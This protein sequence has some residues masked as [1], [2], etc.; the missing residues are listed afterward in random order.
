MRM[1]P[2]PM[3]PPSEP[4]ALQV[5]GVSKHFGSTQALRRVDLLVERASVHALLG[6]NGS[7]K[8]T[9]IKVLAGFHQADQG[10]ISV[11][12]QAIQAHH[13]PRQ[14][15]AAGLR[16]VHQDLGLVPTLSVAENLAL[17][18][19]FLTR[20][21]GTIGWRRQYEHAV[22]ELA[23][24]DIQLDPRRT[25]ATLGPVEQTMVA[26]TRSLLGIEHDRS[27][28]FLD[29]PT[30]RLPRSEVDRLL[31]IVNTLRTRGVAVVYVTHRLDEVFASADTV[32]ILRDGS[33]VFTSSVHGTDESTVSDIIIGRGGS[34]D[35]GPAPAS[36]FSPLRIAAGA[37]AMVGA[38]TTLPG[39][40]DA[41]SVLELR[42]I[43]GR[44]VQGVSLRLAPGEIVAV[45][46]LVGSGRSELGRLIYGIQPLTGGEVW[47]AGR[48]V[49]R[50][51]PRRAKE[52]GLGYSPQERSQA[53]VSG[54][55]VGENLAIT[56]YSGLQ[57]LLGV[58]RRRLRRMAQTVVSNLAIRPPDPDSVVDT[59]SG[60]NQQKVALGKWIRQPLRLLILD[61]PLQGID[62][63][64]KEDIMRAIQARTVRDGL[65]V[66]WLESD[67]QEV[68]KYAT[69]TFVMRDGRI[70]TELTGEV[71]QARLLKAVYDKESIPEATSVPS[72]RPE[73]A[74]L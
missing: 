40:P 13:N 25:L 2:E 1:I 51:T 56:S 10:E 69:R 15:H 44:R 34:S 17:G 59:L 18:S 8:S 24:L 41:A 53:L 29:E 20:R 32:T 61:E 74:T 58:S 12:G 39:K 62:V 57:H 49:G 4:P 22:G 7:G 73:E 66:L 36:G 5:S 55:G 45:T 65:C 27:V 46:G 64:A 30:A 67:I 68:G 42:E 38:G 33:Q 16:F 6:H 71:T 43:S 28:L 63:G 47:L 14:A 48:R 50:L 31:E 60:G 26:V 9:L 35:E 21:G 54:L 37:H 72:H 19:R 3:L 52:S 70:S 11:A 23:R